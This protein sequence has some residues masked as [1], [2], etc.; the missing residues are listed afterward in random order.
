[1]KDNWFKHHP[2]WTGII[3]LFLFLFIVGSLLPEDTPSPTITGKV[4]NEDFSERTEEP[5]KETQPSTYESL[6]SEP[7]EQ[8]ESSDYICSYNAYNCGDFRTHE[9]AQSVFEMCG[10]TSND[11][12]HLDRDADG[13]AC[14][15]TPRENVNPTEQEESSGY[16]CSYNAYNCGDFNTHAE[17]QDVFEMCGGVSNDVHDLDRDSDGSACETLP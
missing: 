5:I 2:I 12:H 9:E 15:T 7:K 8:E 14:E 17:A 4:V 11:V 16:T 3:G 10:G 1:M 6:T 13:S